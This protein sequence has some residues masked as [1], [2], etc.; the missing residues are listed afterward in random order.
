MKWFWVVSCDN[1]V[2]N[3]YIGNL[4]DLFYYQGKEYMFTKGKHIH[5]WDMRSYLGVK[6]YQDD[7]NPD[8][9]LQS[10]IFAPIYSN[11]L[12]VALSKEVKGIQYLP[13]VVKHYDNREIKGFAIANILNMVKAL[14]LN[15]SDYD[16][17]PNDYFISEKRGEIAALRKPVLIGRRILKFNII[18]LYEYSGYVFVSEKF[19]NIFESNGFT[20]YSFHETKLS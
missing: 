9:V 11:R 3:P 13:I 6:T 17:R 1:T 16:I 18:R 2:K 14:D 5:N 8:D 4:K 12:Q 20:G 10:N 19:K 7:G 15:Q